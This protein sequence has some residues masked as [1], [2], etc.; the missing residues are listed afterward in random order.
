V[1]SDVAKGGSAKQGVADGVQKHIGVAV[2]VP[3]GKVK[4]NWDNRTKRP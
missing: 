3:T 4:F 2:A 1:E